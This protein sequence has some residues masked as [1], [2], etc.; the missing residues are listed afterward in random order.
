MNTIT[1]DHGQSVLAVGAPGSIERVKVEYP[2]LIA[3][4][5][6][7]YHEAC[8]SPGRAV[9]EAVQMIRDAGIT[10]YLETNSLLAASDYSLERSGSVTALVMGVA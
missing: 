10:S 3:R 1:N 5:N 8:D 2:K 9:D 4:L 7:L 6:T